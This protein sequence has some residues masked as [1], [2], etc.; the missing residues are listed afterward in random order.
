[1]IIL[2][3]LQS[4]QF[5]ESVSEIPHVEFTKFISVELFKKTTIISS[6][7]HDQLADKNFILLWKRNSLLV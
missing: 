4:Q 3:T 5:I 2:Q 1:M 7:N 6:N